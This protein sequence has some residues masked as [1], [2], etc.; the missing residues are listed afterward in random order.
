MLLAR[1][2]VADVD[3]ALELVRKVRP[4]ARPTR[5]D[6]RFLERIAPRLVR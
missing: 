6:R 1:G 3:A 2:I 5:T 4:P